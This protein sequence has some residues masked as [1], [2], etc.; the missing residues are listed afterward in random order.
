MKLETLEDYDYEIK[1]LESK[2][3][4]IEKYVEEHPERQGVKGNLETLYYVHGEL[5]ERRKFF[6]KKVEERNLLEKLKHEITT[7]S[8]VWCTD[9]EKILKNINMDCVWYNKENT[10]LL[11]ELNKKINELI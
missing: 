9:N 6:L 10:E 7:N 5:I 2:I 1:E 8:G 11:N 3:E 4:E